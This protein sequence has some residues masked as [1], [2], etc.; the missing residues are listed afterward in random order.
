MLFIQQGDP[1]RRTMQR[2]AERN[3]R[4]ECASNRLA[5]RLRLE[6]RLCGLIVNTNNGST[7]CTAAQDS[8]VTKRQRTRLLVIISYDCKEAAVLTRI[9]VGLKGALE[10]Q[11]ITPMAFSAVERVL[12][13][14]THRY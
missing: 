10:T 1:S 5:R 14:T 12:P 3:A 4:G 13:K 9:V 11:T 2:S 8:L 7:A 6:P